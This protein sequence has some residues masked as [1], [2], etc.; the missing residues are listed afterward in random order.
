MRP[1]HERR[2]RVAAHFTVLACLAVLAPTRVAGAGMPATFIFGDS[3]VDAGNNNYIA[4]LSK[5]NYPPNGIDFLGHQPTGR[6]TNGR[7]IVDI[8]AQEMGLEGFIP[9]YMAPETTGDAVMRG[10]NYA[11]GGGGILNQTGSIF[12][13]R[14][15]LDAQIDNYANSRHDLIARH[16]EVAAVSL[17]RGALFTVTTGSNDFINN[18]LTPIFS[19]P[20]RATTPPAAFIGAMIAKYRQQLTRLYL[21]DARKVVVANVGPIGCIPYQR[22]TNPSGGAACAEFPNQ[23]ARSFNRRLR[24]LVDEL[25]A[26]LPGSRFVYADVYR[27]VS[28]IIAKY[29]SHGFEVADSACCYAGGRFGGLVPCGPTSRYCADRSKYVFWDPYHPSDAA[30]EL[31]ARRILDGGPA[32]ISPVNV[33]QLITA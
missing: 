30:N 21:L 14:L 15:N 4:S 10:V 17:L 5:A 20:E 12:G 11:S 27:I 16:G 29:R 9:P 24:A 28:D 32:D 18:Y 3:L 13:G 25:G 22:E 19:V 8:L 7:T 33:R 26:A 23:L 1:P 6:Y 2:P 31:I